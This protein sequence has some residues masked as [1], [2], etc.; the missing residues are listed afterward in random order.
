MVLLRGPLRRHRCSGMAARIGLASMRILYPR[1]YVPYRCIS[2][3]KLVF[4]RLSKSA[5]ISIRLM[6]FLLDK[7]NRTQ[8][9]E[10]CRVLCFQKPTPERFCSY[11]W[12]LTVVLLGSVRDIQSLHTIPLPSGRY[13]PQYIHVS[14]ISK[15]VS[16]CSNWRMYFIASIRIPPPLYGLRDFLFS[17]L[18]SVF[19]I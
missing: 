15:D 4:L 13:L 8:Q 17:F 2:T 16:C 7:K 5:L 3:T 6:V 18:L 14:C 11:P 10:T 1:F 9:V 19:C 12:E